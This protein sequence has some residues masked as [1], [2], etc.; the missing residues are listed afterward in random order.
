[1]LTLFSINR[2]IL[3]KMQ[4][5]FFKTKKRKTLKRSQISTFMLNHMFVSLSKLKLHLEWNDEVKYCLQITSDNHIKL[6]Y[7]L[8]IFEKQQ[9]LRHVVWMCNIVDRMY[10]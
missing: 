5:P 3:A 1:M 9:L 2:K 7:A 10:N 8:K 4:T 6:K